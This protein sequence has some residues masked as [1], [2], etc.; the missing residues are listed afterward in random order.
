M[1]DPGLP[2]ELAAR[3][4]AFEHAPPAPSFDAASWVWMILLGV[5]LPLALLAVGWW[6]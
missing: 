3:I 6:L 4:E 5:A 1:A 2:P